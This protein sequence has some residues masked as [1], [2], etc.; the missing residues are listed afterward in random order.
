MSESWATAT[1]HMFLTILEQRIDDVLD[2]LIL[3]RFGLDRGAI[4]DPNRK[5][6]EDLIDV[7]VRFPSETPTTTVKTVL[8]DEWLD[9]AIKLNSND[10]HPQKL[11]VHRSAL[12]LGP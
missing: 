7:E 10:R 11:E 12:L 1:V 5:K 2:E 4:G 8:K 9:H 6:F 3:K